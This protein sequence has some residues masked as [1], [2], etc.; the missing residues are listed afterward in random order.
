MDHAKLGKAEEALSSPI[1][2]DCNP[3]ECPRGW[4]ASDRPA[5]C[6]IAWPSSYNSTEKAKKSAD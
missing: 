5:R 6:R 2:R 4:N 1:G 3:N